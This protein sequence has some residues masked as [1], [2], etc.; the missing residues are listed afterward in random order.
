MNTMAYCNACGTEVPEGARFC[1]N[2]G[3]A[4]APA[5]DSA[6][7]TP[8]HP[9]IL[10]PP[11]SPAMTPAPGYTPP[12][13]PPPPYPVV[14]G[15]AVTPARSG[16]AVAGFWLGV[17]SIPCCILSW[18][19]VIIGVLGLI[20]GLL[21]LGE[22]RRLGSMAGESPTRFGYRQ[23]SIGIACAVIGILASVAVFVYLLNNLDKYG[24]KITG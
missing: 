12:V 17:A 1:Q 14:P 16:K 7:I 10:P 18:I 21:G 6:P 13:Y 8:S 4:L 9:A 20:F 15:Y 2:C 11:N 22:A 5:A 23:A 3:A 19:G 24:I